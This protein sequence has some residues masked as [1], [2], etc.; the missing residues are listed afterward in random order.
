MIAIQTK[1]ADKIFNSSKG[2][3]Q[4][5]IDL[6]QNDLTE[7]KYSLRI[8]ES[9]NKVVTEQMRVPKVQPDGS[10]VFVMEDVTYKKVLDKKE[11]RIRPMSYEQLD[12]LASQLDI[13][14]TPDSL[15]VNIEEIFRYGLLY[16]TQQDCINGIS[17]PG[18]GIF[19]TSAEDWEIVREE[20]DNR[21]SN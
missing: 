4:L 5:E 10:V 13:T 8:V 18:V 7:G 9:V 3:I 15:R 2:R 1:T 11:P 16:F 21:P 12:T 17:E 14:F 19:F 6:F 20:G